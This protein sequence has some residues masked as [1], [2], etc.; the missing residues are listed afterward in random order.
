MTFNNKENLNN[1]NSETNTLK[2]SKEFKKIKKYKFNKPNNKTISM[3][4][5]N[6]NESNII[7]KFHLFCYEFFSK[8]VNT[9]NLKEKS[10]RHYNHAIEVKNLYMRYGSNKQEPFIKDCSFN[11]DEGDFHVIIGQNGAGKSTLIKMIIGLNLNYQG[12]ILING[13]DRK[14]CDSNQKITFVP[15]KPIFP[16][17]W[18]VFDYL[19]EICRMYDSSNI[20]I[21]KKKINGYLEDFELLNDADKN[22]N[23]LSSGQKQ[24]LLI[25]K[26]LLLKSKII[27]L[28]EPTSNLDAI[29]RKQ[30]LSLLKELSQRNKVTIFISTHVLEEIKYYANSAT[31][32]DKG[33]VLWSGKVSNEEI[34]NKHNEI[35]RV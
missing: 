24:K 15:D 5:S 9:S 7:D 11:V 23:N 20:E 10:S 30:F 16:N 21:L 26:I 14:K 8:K 18:N 2:K 19:L 28:D 27:V 17:E 1:I 34:V 31:F 35:F 3:A 6:R 22:P 12:E 13:I 29:T 4:S 33:K 25:I 32:I